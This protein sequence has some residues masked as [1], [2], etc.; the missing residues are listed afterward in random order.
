MG[1]EYDQKEQIFRNIARS[2]GPFS[3]PVL[4]Y[5]IVSGELFNITAVFMDPSNNVQAVLNGSI[6]EGSGNL[7]R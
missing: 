6:V 7:V 1:A 5:S 2:I 4:T 3:E